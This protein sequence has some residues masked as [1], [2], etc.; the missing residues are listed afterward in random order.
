MIPWWGLIAAGGVMFFAGLLLLC[1]VMISYLILSGQN[2]GNVPTWLGALC[3]GPGML[4]ILAGIPPVMVKGIRTTRDLLR[5]E[6]V[7]THDLRE[8]YPPR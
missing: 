4:L 3:M 8:E 6:W 5:P 2:E 7:S 1:L